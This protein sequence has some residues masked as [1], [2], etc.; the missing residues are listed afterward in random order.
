LRLVHIGDKT[1]ADIAGRW[2]V[3]VLQTVTETG[4]QLTV[5]KNTVKDDEDGEEQFE[6]TEDIYPLGK[7]WEELLLSTTPKMEGTRFAVE[8]RVQSTFDLSILTA[9]S[10]LFTDDICTD[11]QLFF[12]TNLLQQTVLKRQNVKYRMAMITLGGSPI[13]KLTVAKTEIIQLIGRE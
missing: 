1:S 11:F 7:D 9:R 4:R 13:H 3:K 5:L 6:C 2:L 8:F 12:N 10:H